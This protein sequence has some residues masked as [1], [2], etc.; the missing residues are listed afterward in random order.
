LVDAVRPESETA[1]AFSV[2]VENFV[3]GQCKDIQAASEIRALLENWR[4]NNASLQPATSQSFVLRE[5]AP[6]SQ[7]L[8]VVAAAGLNALDYLNHHERPPDQWVGLQKAL[9]EPTLKPGP[10]QL[11]L[12]VA[13]LIQKL[14]DAAAN[15]C[16]TK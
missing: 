4:N 13:P 12:P 2:L 3:S 16:A 10:A 9:I 6:L 5:A 14:V 15:A 7:N 1:G 8:S 11:L